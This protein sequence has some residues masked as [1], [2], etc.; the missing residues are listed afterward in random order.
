MGLDRADLTGDP[1]LPSDRSNAQLINEY[2]NVNAFALNAPGTFGTSPRNLLRNP[3][4]FNLDM[5]LQRNFPIGEK[6]GFQFRVEA[7][8]LPNNVHFNQPGN[9]LSSSNTFGRITSAGDPRILQV[10]GRFEF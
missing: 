6:R 7:F 5:G 2:F 4:Y 3:V 8:N 1:F 9:N 10:V